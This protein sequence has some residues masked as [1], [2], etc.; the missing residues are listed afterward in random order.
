MSDWPIPKPIDPIN[1][2]F[3][4]SCQDGI[5][6]FQRC[7]SCK[8]F[9]HLPRY[10]C[11]SC[12]STDYEWAPCSKTGSLYSW[13]ITHQNFHP[14]FEVPFIAAIVE[15]PEG[16]RMVSQLLDANGVDL[17]LGLAVDVEFKAVGEDFQMPVFRLSA[18]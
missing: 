7:T 11:A 10:M 12:G 16:V 4:Q 14:S 8:K 13:T 9:R 18:E 2:E 17:Q 1:D 3:W 15:F 5:L 6:R